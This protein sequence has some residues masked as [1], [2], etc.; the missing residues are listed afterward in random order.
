ML[1]RQRP[2]E[3]V[4]VC[5]ATV[6]ATAA[7]LAMSLA[8]A[9][10]VARL[11]R[12]ST[13]SSGV[14]AWFAAFG[15][16]A[17]ISVAG[18]ILLEPLLRRSGQLIDGSLRLE[19]V[20]SAL[21]PDT[22][23]HL[24]NSRVQAA[25]TRARAAGAAVWGPGA[26]VEALPTV[27]ATRL[28]LLAFVAVLFLFNLYLGF[29]YLIVTVLN[30]VA[31][32]NALLR[33][34]SG[35]RATRD[36]SRSTYIR[37]LSTS[38]LAAIEVRVFGLEKWLG[39]RFTAEVRSG[40]AVPRGG[41][42]EFS[43]P[44]VGLL[45]VNILVMIATLSRLA[46]TNSSSERAV[47]IVL[48]LYA[49]IGLLPQFVLDDVRLSRGMETSDQV[50]EA[51]A[52][53]PQARPMNE[54]LT[55]CID[56][57]NSE[58]R[59]AEGIDDRVLVVQNACF[60]YEG[61]DRQAISDVSLEI[62]SGRV[63]AVVGANG[64]G[65]TTLAKLL[66]GLIRNDEGTLSLEGRSLETAGIAWWRDRV[67]V[68]FQDFA[69]FES[70]LRE[71]VAYGARGRSISDEEL[72]LIGELSKLDDVVDQLPSGWRTAFGASVSGGSDLSGGQWQRV[73]LARALMGVRHGARLLI[74]DE[75]TSNLDP[76]AEIELFQSCADL[77]RFATPQGSALPAI[78]LISHRLAGVRGADE[79][80]VMDAG[81]IVEH[82]THA[83]LY[84]LGGQ[85]FGM[86]DTQ[87]RRY[88]DSVD[89]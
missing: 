53:A 39:A 79:I 76:R 63:V 40:V 55:S 62:A 65:K 72:Q 58:L 41:A 44:L 43:K 47:I 21:S 60:R 84:E 59:R 2:S 56:D 20:E 33:V 49:V 71:N 26:A 42:R 12:S 38:A 36:L 74:L 61:S 80:L 27:V 89:E 22:V 88:L 5:L 69:R 48:V 32:H 85:Y 75:P 15:A 28:R 13:E 8:T 64:S 50:L 24:E 9:E 16:L 87:A 10:V 17:L 82:G 81:R 73:A 30:Q 31:M 4:P 19:V 34:L 18:G 37:D 11:S 45:C 77:V 3:L 86:F 51:L 6:V 25:F 83:E 52:F 35:G 1:L 46:Q 14:L 78:L 29:A 66:C 57:I 68:L 23:T 70:T 54:R 7:P 67:S